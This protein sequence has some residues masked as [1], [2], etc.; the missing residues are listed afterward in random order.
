MDPTL[1]VIAFVAGG[2]LVLLLLLGF[3]AGLVRRRMKAELESRL[4]GRR[5]LRRS[6]RANFFGFA[7]LGPAQLRGNGALVLLPEELYFLMAAPRREIRIPLVRITATSLVKSHLGKTIF[8]SLLHV[9][10]R[11][12]EGDDAVA[13][14]VP[15]PQ[16]WRDA[17]D[18]ACGRQP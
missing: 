7:S 5:V 15:D 4:P 10:Y 13:W 3:I 18:Q 1:T 11:G 12:G 8:R 9:A 6:L 2:V 16:G 14:A 17:I